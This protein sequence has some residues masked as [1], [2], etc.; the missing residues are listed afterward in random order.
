VAGRPILE[1]LVLQLLGFGIRRVFLSVNYLAS[2]IEEHF[3]DGARHGC[4]IEYLREDRPLGTGGPLSLLPEV[5]RD[6]ILVMNGDLVTQADLGS[7]LDSH[8]RGGARATV[9]LRRYFHTVP[10]G[11]VERD[12]SRIVSFEEKPTLTRLINAGIYVLDPVLLER[13]PRGVDFPLPSL[14]QDCLTRGEEVGGFEIEDDWIDVGQR[15]E[16]GRASG[17][18]V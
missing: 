9:G 14:L 11:C 1:R 4:R 17:H 10:F 16:L 13:I 3:G 7:L 6:P 8:A 2:V 18:Q 15:E 5:P 12:G